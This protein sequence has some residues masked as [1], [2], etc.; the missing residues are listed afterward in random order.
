[1]AR[2]N[3]LCAIFL[4]APN[5]PPSRARFIAGKTSGFLYVVSVTGVTG[6]RREI[7]KE[8]T[9]YLKMLRGVTNKPLVVG[10]GVSSPS[11]VGDIGY[12]CDGL[13]FGSALIDLVS[14][15]SDKKDGHVQV[16]SFINSLLKAL[17]DGELP[18]KCH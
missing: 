3:N 7:P 8:L 17:L 15:Y 12:L 2:A 1:M 6:K 5:T 11:H 14:H 9:D 4:V 13:I 16:K 18:L 10:F